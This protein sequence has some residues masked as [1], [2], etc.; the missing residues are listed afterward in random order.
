MLVT[1]KEILKIAEAEGC[2]IGSFNTPNL[3]SLSAVIG[4]AEELKRPVIIMHAQLHEEMGICS[5]DTIG[6]IMIMA[7]E[8]ASVP[9]C[10]HL[11]HGT[12]LSYIKSALDLGFT[13][14]M[15][16]GSAL[17]FAANS[18]NTQIE[19]SQAAKYGASVEGEIG[20]MGSREGGEKSDTEE[21]YTKP[22]DAVRFTKETGINALACS[23]G[24]AHGIYKAAPKLDFER[25]EKIKSFVNVPLVMHGGSGISEEGFRKAISC[26]I[27]KINYYTYM[28]KAG[29]TAVS[30]M[31]DLTF[32][33]DIAKAAELAMKEDAKHAIKIFSNR[34]E[35]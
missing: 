4:A 33:H 19:V 17:P 14:V 11:D 2:A 25:V 12:D 16:D 21:M 3:E 18:A 24:T 8:K 20:S 29:G 30:A 31:D 10:V 5:L 7:A 26:G 23:F 9:V 22:D 32:W 1:L 35:L 28:A 34:E 13:S 27:R 15:Y 6:R